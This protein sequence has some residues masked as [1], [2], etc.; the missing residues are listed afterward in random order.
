M[1]DTERRPEWRPVERTRAYEEVI[2]QVEA[3]ISA[4]ALRVGDR[5]PAERDLASRLGVSRAAVREA[6]RALEAIGVVSAG[7]GR[8][9]GT[10]LS[11]MSSEALTQLLRLH[12][13][14]AN[15]PMDDVIEARIMLERWSATLA[16]K[17]ATE[18]DRTSLSALVEGM[19]HPDV[20]EGRFNDLDTEFHVAIARAGRNQLV[21]DM[22]SAIR[23]SMRS[24]ILESFYES[25]RW[26]QVRDELRHGHRAILEAILDGHPDTAADAVEDHIRHAFDAL[27][28][29]TSH[30]D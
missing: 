16:A 19:E 23:S 29:R 4:G 6:M 9:A 22:T 1:S 2:A 3:Q 18:D 8:D 25:P 28:W 26:E 20:D 14:L 13:L 21:S 12:I 5:L 15:F 7:A 24:S 11:S 10:V 27:S 30:E 17:N